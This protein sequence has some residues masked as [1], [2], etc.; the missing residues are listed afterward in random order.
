MA[1]A[2]TD[3]LQIYSL[4]HPQIART[5][6]AK[7]IKR[8][9]ELGSAL[10]DGYAEDWGDYKGRAGVIKGLDEAIA[11]CEQVEKEGRS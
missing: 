9:Q 7:L 8:R 4:D 10:A 5:L 3:A 11:I 6:R 1:Q 2:V